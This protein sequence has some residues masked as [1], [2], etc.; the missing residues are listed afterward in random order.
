MTRGRAHRYSISSVN[1]SSIALSVCHAASKLLHILLIIERRSQLEFSAGTR[2][3]NCPGAAIANEDRLRRSAMVKWS[4]RPNIYGEMVSCIVAIDAVGV[5]FPL[6]VL[7]CCPS[8]HRNAVW[9][10][11]FVVEE[12]GCRCGARKGWVRNDGSIFDPGFPSF[13]LFGSPDLLCRRT[14]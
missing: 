4:V 10:V 7:F 12:D 1:L 8:M 9:S 13:R 11:L 3:H 2:V 14:S 5:R 6:D